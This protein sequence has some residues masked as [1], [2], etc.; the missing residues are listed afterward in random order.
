[1]LFGCVREDVLFK[2]IRNDFRRPPAAG[3]AIYERVQPGLTKGQKIQI[4]SN[5]IN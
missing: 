5:N 4:N 2:K 3:V 1:M